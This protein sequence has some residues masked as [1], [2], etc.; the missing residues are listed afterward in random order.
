MNIEPL[1]Q[2]LIAKLEI[3]VAHRNRER[4]FAVIERHFEELDEPRPKGLDTPLA[5]ILPMRQASLLAKEGYLLVSDLAGV[6]E[7]DL[8]EIKGIGK[9]LIARLREKLN[10]RLSSDSG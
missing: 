2:K 4:A 6:S 7:A 8:A 5:D 9:Q 3:A 10:Q 1:C